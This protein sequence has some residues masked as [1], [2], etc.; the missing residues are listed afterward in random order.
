MNID[1]RMLHL[2][3]FASLRRLFRREHHIAFLLSSQESSPTVKPNNSHKNV[4]G[5]NARNAGGREIAPETFQRGGTDRLMAALKDI[6]REKIEIFWATHHPRNLRLY[7]H[8]QP[9]NRLLLSVHDTLF[10]LQNYQI[11]LKNC[12]ENVEIS[13][14]S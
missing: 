5:G 4:K 2:L 8:F 13:S 6:L 12:K 1:I 3:G 14:N 10:W 11:I 7:Q 9:V